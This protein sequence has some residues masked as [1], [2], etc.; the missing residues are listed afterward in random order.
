M[1]EP[2][3]VLDNINLIFHA[4]LSFLCWFLSLLRMW[5]SFWICWCRT[6]WKCQWTSLSGSGSRSFGHTDVGVWGECWASRIWLS[7]SMEPDSHRGPQ[8]MVCVLTYEGFIWDR[9]VSGERDEDRHRVAARRRTTLHVRMIMRW[10][11][12]I[13]V[14]LSIC[15]FT[16]WTILLW[17]V[18][19]HHQI[20]DRL[21]SLKLTENCAIVVGRWNHWR[22]QNIR[23]DN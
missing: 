18:Q 22:I 11:S 5:N 21:C 17:H 13:T 6:V 15:S 19:Q 4:R 2:L 7:W 9:L 1:I 12:L 16:Q 14:M 23:R 20:S 3:N 8:E 10:S